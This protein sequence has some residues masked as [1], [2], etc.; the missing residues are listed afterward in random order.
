MLLVL[1]NGSIISLSTAANG[2]VYKYSPK[3]FDKAVIED[4]ACARRGD[5]TRY[6]GIRNPTLY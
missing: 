5:Q 3:A 2:T 1:C 4:T 6:L